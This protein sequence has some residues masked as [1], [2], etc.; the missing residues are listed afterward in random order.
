MPFEIVKNGRALRCGYTT[1]S[2]AAAAAKAA[3]AALLSGREQ[4]AVELMTPAGKLLT[5]EVAEFS[6]GEDRVRCGIKKDAGD[7]PDVTDGITVFAEVTKIPA[8]ITVEGG[9]GVG[10]V[11]KPG[12]ACRVGEAAI[13]PVP[14][15][16]I[17]A[18]L[19]E[20]ARRYSYSGG[21]RVVISAPEGEGLAAK[22]FNPRLGI[23]GGISIL[24]TTGIVEPMSEAALVDTVKVEIDSRIAA[25]ERRLLFTPG[26]YGRDFALDALGL[27]LETGVKCSNFIGEALDYAGYRGVEAV[28][29]VG[30]A[31]KLVKLAAGVMNTHSRVADCR[32]EVM[33]AHAALCGADRETVREIFDC[34]TTE[35][36]ERLLSERGLSDAVWK[37]V[38]R[39]I[40]EHLGR[41]TKVKTEVVVFTNGCGALAK[42]PGAEALAARIR[43]EQKER[44]KI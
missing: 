38:L 2:C 24:G 31:G 11:T 42:T 40:C 32:A 23:V 12:L 28:L 3:A 29:L 13:N 16:M 10:Q 39:K 6:V 26:N 4:V 15:R 18:A 34:A 22:T 43:E 25:G 20:T 35:E 44:E 5:L 41:R 17:K 19:N 36:M 37:S 14:R 9:R 21:F 1:G 7:D 8:G 33:A 27:D 30:H